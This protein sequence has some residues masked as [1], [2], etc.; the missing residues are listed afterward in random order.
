MLAT[1]RLYTVGRGWEIWSRR[2]DGTDRRR[3]TRNR[4]NDWGPA[5]SPEGARIAYCSGKDDRYEIWM[6]ASGANP[7]R[8]TR[9]VYDGR[10]PGEPNP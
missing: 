4:V 6:E 2:D 5:Y 8:L 7:K 9:L 10:A 3:L 1:A